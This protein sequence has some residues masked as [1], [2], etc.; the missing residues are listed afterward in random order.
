MKV[1]WAGLIACLTSAL[2]E[3]AQVQIP[4]RVSSSRDFLSNCFGVAIALAA[5][6]ILSKKKAI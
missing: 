3:L 5:I 6:S 1:Y 4:G 2:A